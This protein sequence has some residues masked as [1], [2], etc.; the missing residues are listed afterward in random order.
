MPFFTNHPPFIGSAQADLLLIEGAVLTTGAVWLPKI[1]VTLRGHLRGLCAGHL[2]GLCA[3]HLHALG[4][5]HLHALGAVLCV[6][7]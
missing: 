6:F 2:R 3:G 7:L 1:F 5:G 4:A